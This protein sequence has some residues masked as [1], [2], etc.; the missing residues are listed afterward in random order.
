MHSGSL[1]RPI[2]HLCV[3]ARVVG[4]A[5]MMRYTRPRYDVK[6]QKQVSELFHFDLTSNEAALSLLTEGAREE[7]DVIAGLNGKVPRELD[8]YVVAAQVRKGLG[9][10]NGATVEE[11][12][13]ALLA[14]DPRVDTELLSKIARE[15]K[16]L[17]S[18]AVSRLS[19]VAAVRELIRDGRA[20]A[21]QALFSHTYGAVENLVVVIRI[22][23]VLEGD[24][25]KVSTT[26][27]CQRFHSAYSV[28]H[29]VC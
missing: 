7:A 1:D 22:E 15:P 16:L 14:G 25:Q 2:Y 8:A 3:C 23:K 13:V 18:D 19:E 17:E 12:L 9:K 10:S 26:T 6:H 11:L 27:A 29:A 5:L 20:R 21:P 24:T 28:D 4:F